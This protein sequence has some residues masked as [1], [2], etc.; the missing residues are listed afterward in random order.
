MTAL[1]RKEK[2]LYKE[3]ALLLVVKF[4]A[5]T[6]IWYAFYRA[7]VIPSMIDG[8]D[9]GQV[10]AAVLRHSIEAGVPGSGDPE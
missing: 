2:P 8:M 7:P 10:T 4:L 9:P 6:M 5:L 1:L 3:I